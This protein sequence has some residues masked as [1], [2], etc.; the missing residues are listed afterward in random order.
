LSVPLS[1]ASGIT[2][3][4]KNA[5]KLSTKGY[6]LFVGGTPIKFRDFSWNASVNFTKYKSVVDELAPGVAN[7]FLAGFTT[8]NIRL[9]AGDEYGQIYGSAYQRNADGQLLLS[10]TTGLPLP[11]ADVVKIGNPNPDY[12]MGISNDFNYKSFTFSFLLDIRKGGDQYSRNIADVQRNGVAAETGEF[13]RFEADGVTQSKP[14]LF[15]GVYA[16]GA[17]AGA[18]NTI[19]VR[20]QDYYGNAGKYVAAEGYIY[21]TS[22]FRVREAAFNYRLPANLVKGFRTIEI[23]AFGRNLYLKAKNYPHFDPEQNALGVSNAQ[24]LEFNSLPSTRTFGLNLKL[25][26]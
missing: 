11:T 13:A 15:P 17:N 14:Y 9:V 16:S 7:I 1:A 12:T 8:P 3:V 6:E 25:V 10:P 23:G 18:A 26:L 5:G 19:N 24:G 4:V 21:D 22:W 2:S 20:A